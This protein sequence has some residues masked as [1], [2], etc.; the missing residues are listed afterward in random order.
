MKILSWR[1]CL[2]CLPTVDTLMRKKVNVGVGCNFCDSPIED[3]AHALL[4]CPN[5]ASLWPLYLP[6]IE[7]VNRSQSI[8]E[9]AVQV[10][11]LRGMQALES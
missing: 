1:T 9:I 10:K 4:N 8:Y 5:F 2:E 7:R 3:S 6:V 11:N